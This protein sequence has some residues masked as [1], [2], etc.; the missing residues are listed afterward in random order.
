MLSFTP[1]D[2]AKEGH[3]LYGLNG[4][5]FLAKYCLGL[6]AMYIFGAFIWLT[7]NKISRKSIF[8]ILGIIFINLTNILRLTLLFMHIQKHGNYELAMDLHEMFNIIIYS[9]IFIL[10]IIWIEKFSDLWSKKYRMSKD[11]SS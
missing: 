3:T 7:G 6:Q 4:N 1:Y 10:W 5:L 8:I 11:S 2:V 9:L